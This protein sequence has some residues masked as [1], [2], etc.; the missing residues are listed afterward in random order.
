MTISEA[1]RDA[2]HNQADRVVDAL[3]VDG[4]F[5][6]TRVDSDAKVTVILTDGDGALVELQIRPNHRFLVRPEP[7]DLGD[8]TYRRDEATE[9]LEEALS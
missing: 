7:G 9:F 4:A 8:T 2:F 3:D 6:V 5:E 1:D